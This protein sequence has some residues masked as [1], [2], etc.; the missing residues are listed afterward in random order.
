MHPNRSIP[1]STVIP[2]LDYPDIAKAAAW[3]CDAFGFTVRLTIGDHRIQMNVG[4]QGA[5]VLRQSDQALTHMDSV[6][7]RIADVKAHHAHSSKHGARVIGE[8]SDQPFGERQYSVADLVGRSWTFS[9]TIGDVDP[10]DWG[11]E[12]GFL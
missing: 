9:E 12:P 2:V 8:P 7:V 5:V 6:L 4:E 10:R 1:K 3:L 11:G